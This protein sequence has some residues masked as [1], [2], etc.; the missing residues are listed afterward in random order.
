[1]ATCI[2]QE[3]PNKVI[4]IQNTQN[5]A[6]KYDLI[7]FNNAVISASLSNPIITIIII[8]RC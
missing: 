5:A 2:T 1:M 4:L 8:V 3:L 6:I 7:H